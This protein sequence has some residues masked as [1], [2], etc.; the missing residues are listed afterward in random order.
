MQSSAADLSR[1]VGAE[2]RCLAEC[3]FTHCA[4]HSASTILTLMFTQ[5]VSPVGGPYFDRHNMQ[6]DARL[7][8]QG[9]VRLAFMA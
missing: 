4:R 1:H 2:R 6:Q 3:T 5:C 9:V 7:E 8:L